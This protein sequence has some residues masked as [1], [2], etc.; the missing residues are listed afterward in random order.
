MSRITVSIGVCFILFQ[1]TL[2]DD[3]ETIDEERTSNSSEV[4]N[5]VSQENEKFQVKRSFQPY[6]MEPYRITSNRTP[7]LGTTPLDLRNI[8][9]AVQPILTSIDEESANEFKRI[10]DS[11]L[12]RGQR[13]KKLKEWAEKRG[14]K[15]LQIWNMQM[16]KWT[17]QK[18]KWDMKL[19]ESMRMLSAAAKDVLMK[20]I[21][22]DNDP[23]INEFQSALEI[24][25]LM[26]RTNA[27]IS[28]EIYDLYQSF[29]TG[30][31]RRIGNDEA[32]NA[33]TTLLN[34]L[35]DASTSQQLS[36]LNSQAS[37]IKTNTDLFD[38]RV[39]RWLKRTVE[40]DE[41]TK[42]QMKQKIISWVE[43]QNKVS[44]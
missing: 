12:P 2:G 43:K 7:M 10:L 44:L 34:F 20:R 23:T 14:G 11:N 17:K 6:K 4:L 41:L 31:K 13:M 26:S 5:G 32:L 25:A 24:D 29:V 36:S 1:V 9:A 8:N 22:I 3:L 27:S 33:C 35:K 39:L 16:Q 18:A 30:N 42:E 38:E 28:N 37:F 15:T 21:Q 40:D 19:E